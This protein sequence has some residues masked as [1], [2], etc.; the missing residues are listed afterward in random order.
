MAGGD[1]GRAGDSIREHLGEIPGVLTNF[2]QPIQ[3]SVEELLEGVRAELA[4][5][6]FGDD[7]DILKTRR[8]RSRRSW[9]GSVARPTSR[10]TRSRARRSS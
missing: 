6:L 3:M 8:T 2:T 1:P 7:L 5:K 10:R 9:R 4:I